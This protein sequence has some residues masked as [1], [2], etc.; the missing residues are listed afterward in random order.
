MVLSSE[1]APLASFTRTMASYINILLTRTVNCLLTKQKSYWQQTQCG[2]VCDLV[3]KRKKECVSVRSSERDRGKETQPLMYSRFRFKHLQVSLQGPIC[4][5][6]LMLT[7]T[8]DST[9]CLSTAKYRAKGI[10]RTLLLLHSIFI[11]ICVCILHLPLL[12]P[13]MSISQLVSFLCYFLFLIFPVIN[14]TDNNASVFTAS[15]RYFSKTVLT[16]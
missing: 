16:C 6:H 10:R 5:M 12:H 14:A 13:S 15:M 7:P 1:P 3:H 11:H 9:V 8:F 4:R 2:C